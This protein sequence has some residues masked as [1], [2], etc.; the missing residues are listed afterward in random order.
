MD[1]FNS[2]R[3]SDAYSKLSIIGSVPIHYL[4]QCW[5]IVNLTL[6]NKL[7]W[8]VNWN[9]YIFIRENAFEYVV[10]EAAAILSQ[11]QCVKHANN[12]VTNCCQNQWWS[13]QQIHVSVED[14]AF[15]TLRPRQNG[16]RFPDDSSKCIFLNGNVW[17][18]IENS[19]KFV[20]RG[21]INNIPALVQIM[22]SRRRGEKSLSEPVM[23]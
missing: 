11:P 5:N 15:N 8:N 16:R 12:H 1:I 18:S 22:A 23:V 6:R 19:L 2:L 17:I 9:S 3:L 14:S 21:P 7:Q 4:S 13:R 10:C 20:P